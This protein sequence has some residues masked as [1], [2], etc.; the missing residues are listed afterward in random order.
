MVF[1]VLLI[2]FLVLDINYIEGIK[3]NKYKL[4]SGFLEKDV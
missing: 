4:Y 2:F 1:L 3:K